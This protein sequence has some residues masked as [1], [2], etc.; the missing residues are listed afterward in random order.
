MTKVI[1]VN[2]SIEEQEKQKEYEPKIIEFKKNLLIYQKTAAQTI[3][4]KNATGDSKNFHSHVLFNYYPK[5][6]MKV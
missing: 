3:L 2:L 1:D 6:I 5:L 4:S